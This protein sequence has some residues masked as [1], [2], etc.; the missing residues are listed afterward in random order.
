MSLTRLRRI[1][2]ALTI[3]LPLSLAGQ[4]AG[5]QSLQDNLVAQLREQG[6][7]D[8]EVSRTL[9]GRIQIIAIGPDYRREIVFNPNNGEILRDYLTS[10][11]GQMRNP[12]LVAPEARERDDRDTPSARGDDDDDD[13]RDDNDDDRDDDDSDDDDSDD[14]DDDGDDD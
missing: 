1:M 14:D 5:A 12:L 6:F 3:I 7:V 9:L 8:F 11:T 2:L 4:M 13:D 10:T